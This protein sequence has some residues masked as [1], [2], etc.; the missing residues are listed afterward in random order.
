MAEQLPTILE[1]H[2]YI[3][4][5]RLELCRVQSS[6]TRIPLAPVVMRPTWMGP[7]LEATAHTSASRAG[8][9]LEGRLET[10][11]PQSCGPFNVDPLQGRDQEVLRLLSQI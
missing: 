4:L 10:P 5:P 2:F 3:H 9:A 7:G 11:P 1:W 8:R 6:C